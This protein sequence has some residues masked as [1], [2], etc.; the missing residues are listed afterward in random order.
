MA[1]QLSHSLP[2]PPRFNSCDNERH[3][4]VGPVTGSRNP[5]TG[6]NHGGV[7]NDGDE[8][9]V[10]TRLDPNDAKA[11][12]GILLGDALDQSGQHFPIRWLRLRLHDVHRSGLVAK[13]LAPGAEVQRNR[14]A[15][16]WDARQAAISA[17]SAESSP[18][19]PHAKAISAAG[20]SKARG[21]PIAA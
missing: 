1:S 18:L 3:P 20:R 19:P 8:I 17:I 4:A 10:A 12:V 2:A 15:T 9:A 13:T 5:L 16:G 21:R 7:A 14:A 6:G 11:V